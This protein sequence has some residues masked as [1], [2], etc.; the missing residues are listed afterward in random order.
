M[1]IKPYWENMEYTRHKFPN[2]RV[3]VS[4]VEL[5]LALLR[6]FRWGYLCF[7]IIFVIQMVRYVEVLFKESLGLEKFGRRLV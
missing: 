5:Y 3:E 7:R 2:F 4:R 1:C 6:S